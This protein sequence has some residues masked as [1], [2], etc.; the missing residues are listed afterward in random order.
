MRLYKN[1]DIC[2]LASIIEKGILSMDECGNC[3]WGEGK[4]A[5]NDTSLV[6]LFRPIK[7]CNSFPEYG[8]ALLE[9]EC[10][11]TLNKMLDNDVHKNDYEE[12]V[13]DKVKSEDIKRV[14]I[15]EIFQEFI[16]I[17]EGIEISWCGF[18]ANYY[19]NSE[20]CNAGDDVL[21]QFAKTAPLEDAMCYN[22]FR[23]VEENGE[24]MD[25]Y[26]VVYVFEQ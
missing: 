26:D 23:G 17:P 4:R 13:V 9:V 11:A 7:K 1:V 16:N 3:N 25:L 10:D 20:K 18:Q 5:S 14:I 19:N 15:P 2:D 12:Y 22:F 24:V 8:I 6:Y 21:K